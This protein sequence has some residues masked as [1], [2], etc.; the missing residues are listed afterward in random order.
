MTML[1]EPEWQ[2]KNGNRFGFESEAFGC[3]VTSKIFRPDVVL[4]CDEVGG[5]I[6]MT[7]DGRIG[8]DKV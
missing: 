7:G 2:D 4:L 6:D 8:G 5:N 1:E 3:E